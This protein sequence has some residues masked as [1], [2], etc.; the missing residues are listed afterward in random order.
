V[1]LFI[2][3]KLRYGD[4]HTGTWRARDIWRNAMEPWEPWIR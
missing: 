2:G 4:E 3:V 1:N